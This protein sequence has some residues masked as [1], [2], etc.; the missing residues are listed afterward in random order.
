MNGKENEGDIG[1]TMESLK[2]DKDIIDLDRQFVNYILDQVNY[3]KAKARLLEDLAENFRG[4]T[5]ETPAGMIP[6]PDLLNE[7]SKAINYLEKAQCRLSLELVRLKSLQMVHDRLIYNTE[8]P[9]EVVMAPA[10]VSFQ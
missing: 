8:Q 4:K 9:G 1:R 2:T 10:D 3:V 5:G 7:F 6:T